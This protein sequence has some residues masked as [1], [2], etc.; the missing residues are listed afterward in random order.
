VLWFETNNLY[1]SFSLNWYILRRT[2]ATSTKDGQ[3]ERHE[4]VT[5]PAR[6]CHHSMTLGK[7][8]WSEGEDVILRAKPS[9]RR[10]TNKRVT[11]GAV[12]LRPLH[13]KTKARMAGAVALRPLHRKTKARPRRSPPVPRPSSRPEAHVEFSPL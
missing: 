8:C 4:C 9:S 13:R 11:A 12:T 10:H 7:Y 1:L 5:S 3:Q 6:P 2:K